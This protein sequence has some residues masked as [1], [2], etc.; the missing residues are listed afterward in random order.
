M[1]CPS[2]QGSTQGG[3]RAVRRLVTAFSSSPWPF[4]LCPLLHQA[5]GPSA[6]FPPF[7]PVSQERD[8][9][10]AG[11]PS[12]PLGLV[13]PSH[14]EGGPATCWTRLWEWM[15]LIF[16][17]SER[18]APSDA[19]LRTC[20]FK[21]YPSPWMEGGGQGGVRGSPVPG[22]TVWC[23]ESRLDVILL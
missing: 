11:V 8:L 21:G 23:P 4:S 1:L 16:E 5:H 19:T 22:S 14:C 17:C 15:D 10:E 9:P 7:L 13:E 20:R 6:P 3:L 2:L 12:L 18:A